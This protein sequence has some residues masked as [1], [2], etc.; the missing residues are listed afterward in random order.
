MKTFKP[1]FDNHGNKRIFK[2]IN[3][4]TNESC[5]C[6]GILRFPGIRSRRG[7][8]RTRRRGPPARI[9]GSTPIHLRCHPGTPYSIIRNMKKTILHQAG[10][11]L[12]IQVIALL[13]LSS[14]RAGHADIYRW[15][16]DRG[17]IH[18]TDDLGNIPQKFRG[19]QMPILKG[20]PASGQPSLS[21]I[22][23]PPSRPADAPSPPETE[24]TTESSTAA[25]EDLTGKAEQL[26]AKVAAKE[27]FLEGVDRKRSNIL[28]PLGNRFVSPEDLELYGKYR[29]ELPQDRERLREIESLLPAVK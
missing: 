4:L 14:P 22:E 6:G 27:Q 13:A 29:K 25:G 12:I 17:V 3:V 21:T 28:N 24:V 2:A 15:E 11:V 16:D 1:L 19:R 20:P 9:A 7:L 5:A 18:F 23:S 26:R 8:P 10:N